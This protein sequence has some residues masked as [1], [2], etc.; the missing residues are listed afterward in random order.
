VF[1]LL[2]PP[3]QSVMRYTDLS[4][5]IVRT[6][7]HVYAYGGLADIYLG[8]WKDPSSHGENP[9][10]V[11]IKSLRGV[12]TEPELM[13][14]VSRRLH[15]EASLWK[16]LSHPNILPFLGICVDDDVGPSP[17]MISPLCKQGN[18]LK[19]LLRNPGAD[20]LQIVIGLAN[21]LQY[22]HSN[23]IIHGD[24]KAHNVLIDDFGAS[25]LCDF[26]RS[27]IIGHRGYTTTFSGSARYMAP[28]ILGI[29]P[30]SRD[31]NESGSQND[32]LVVYEEAFVPKLTKETDVYAF[33]V[34]SLEILTG[35]APYYY[36]ATDPIFQTHILRGVRP[37]REKYL[38]P[39]LTDVLWTLLADCWAQKPSSR[40]SMEGVIA[41]LIQM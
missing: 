18:V 13:E 10:P 21:G 34:L 15:R 19:Y 23:D 35:K 7:K 22:L 28:E 12:H 11:A 41:R 3:N 2:S 8:E 1:E 29:E 30:S 39:V 36:I 32:A 14:E 27:R 16:D 20:R 37:R 40:L 6:G 26:G 4:G 9:V 38:S 5:Q 24:L 17:V 33:A 25:C 31:T